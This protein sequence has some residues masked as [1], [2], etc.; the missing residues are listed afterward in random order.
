M[1]VGRSP[2]VDGAC[3]NAEPSLSEPI[4]SATE[5]NWEGGNAGISPTDGGNT[6]LGINKAVGS[7]GEGISE[8]D[9]ACGSNSWQETES[10]AVQQL[11]AQD[12]QGNTPLNAAALSGHYEMTVLLIDSGADLNS[13]GTR[14][15]SVLYPRLKG[16]YL[17]NCSLLCFLRNAFLRTLHIARRPTP[18]YY[19]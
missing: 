15:L 13:P 8:M 4:S 2:C 3:T 12:S 6:R 9:M 11:R 7:V 16:T 19:V 14:T 17:L 5:M 10:L 18:D 1:Q